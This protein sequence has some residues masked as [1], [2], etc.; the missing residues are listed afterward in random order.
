M[1]SLKTSTDT[2]AI[3]IN[4][5]IMTMIIMTMIIMIT[6]M[7]PIIIIKVSKI[8]LG[9]K[10]SHHAVMCT[11]IIHRQG[12]LNNAVSSRVPF[13]LNNPSVSFFPPS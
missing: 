4:T 9:H 2:K 8:S 1:L 5:T 6:I 12:L 7:I 11:M 10:K 3:A 13:R